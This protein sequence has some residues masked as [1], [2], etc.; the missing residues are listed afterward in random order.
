MQPSSNHRRL[1]LVAV[2]IAFAGCPCAGSPG[3][4]LGV[5]P[6]AAFVTE[7]TELYISAPDGIRR[8]SLDGTRS[9]KVF[10]KLPHADV[11]KVTVVDLSL[12]HKRW[13]LSDS[14]TNLWI[15]DAATGNTVEIK[16]LHHRM[17]AAA[18]SPDGKM[19]AATRHSDYSGFGNKPND[20][21]IY[22][23]DIATRKVDV[24]PAQTHDWPV[25]IEWSSDGSALWLTMAWEQGF[26][27]V[28]LADR[29]RTSHPHGNPPPVQKPLRDNP[30][31]SPVCPQQ[32]VH[33]EDPEL[34]IVEDPQKPAR[35][36][37]RIEGRER[38][39]HDHL[40]DFSHEAMTPSCKYV[41]FE[42]AQKI[43]VSDLSGVVAPIASGDWLF[44]AM[45][46]L[47]APP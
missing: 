5:R 47:A 26:Q 31:Q 46:P 6:N 45:A 20:D 37:V 11:P 24:I 10:A 39:F 2:A 8:I 43:W 44:F 36:L 38:G 9:T 22:L 30:K 23:I 3:T 17:S 42:H 18:I 27:W 29:A 7:Q 33:S 12:D 32:L 14:D 15:G 16:E 1:A 13:L 40:P 28:T 21:A 35:V 19:I 4:L 25:K 41:V 34:R